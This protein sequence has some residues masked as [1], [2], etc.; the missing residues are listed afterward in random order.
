MS[1]HPAQP[2]IW[3]TRSETSSRVEAGSVDFARALLAAMMCLKTLAAAGP[4]MTFRRAS[5]VHSCVV[6]DGYTPWTEQLP[7]LRHERM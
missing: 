4:A 7:Q 3:L 6:V 1:M 2:L 5:M